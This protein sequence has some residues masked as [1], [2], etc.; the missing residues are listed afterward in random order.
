MT[1]PDQPRLVHIPPEG[2]WGIDAVWFADDRERQHWVR[3]GAAAHDPRLRPGHQ[4]YGA[5]C[6]TPTWLVP[7]VRSAVWADW[8]RCTDCQLACDQHAAETKEG[9]P[10]AKDKRTPQEKA[11]WKGGEFSAKEAREAGMTKAEMNKARADQE[12]ELGNPLAPEK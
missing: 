10:M 9:K 6:G 3:P 8:P 2:R 11:A 4:T 5:A 12:R 7:D 1:A